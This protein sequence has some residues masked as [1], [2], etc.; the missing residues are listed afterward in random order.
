[1]AAGKTVKYGMEFPAGMDALHIELFCLRHDTR[2]DYEGG[3][4]SSFASQV[5]QENPRKKRELNGSH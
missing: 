5:L 3:R 4:L 1:M 2:G